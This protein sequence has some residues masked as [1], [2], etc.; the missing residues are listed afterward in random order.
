MARGPENKARGQKKQ[1]C[2]GSKKQGCQGS[3]K[4][5]GVKKTR[6]GVKKTR[7]PRINSRHN[8]YVLLVDLI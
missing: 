7:G 4:Q 8:K 6:S 2:Q 5:G 3:E 1:G